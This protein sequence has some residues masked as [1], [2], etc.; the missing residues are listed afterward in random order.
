MS[1]KLK[2]EV[3][4]PILGVNVVLA[5]DMIVLAPAIVPQS[6]NKVL[7]KQLKVPLNQDGFFLEA[8]AKL[9]PVDFATDGIFL[10]GLAHCP[11]SIHESISQANAAASHAIGRLKAFR[12]KLCEIICNSQVV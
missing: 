8:H 10:C 9:R 5:A 11:K 2:V 7:A 12:S 6:D 3:F 1:D 4:D